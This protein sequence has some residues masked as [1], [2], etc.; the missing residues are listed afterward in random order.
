MHR[1]FS[2]SHPSVSDSWVWLGSVCRGSFESWW[3]FTAERRKMWFWVLH[4]LTRETSWH[5]WCCHENGDT[6]GWR[7]ESLPPC[8]YKLSLGYSCAAGLNIRPHLEDK[9]AEACKNEKRGERLARLTP[10]F[11]LT[12]V[13]AGGAVQW[14]FI[15]FYSNA[16]RPKDS[17]C[18]ERVRS[19][20]PLA[21]SG[22]FRGANGSSSGVCDGWRT[23]LQKLEDSSS[24]L[25]HRYSSLEL[26]TQQDLQPG[27]F[28]MSHCPLLPLVTHPH[29]SAHRGATCSRW[30]KS[31]GTSL[32]HSHTRGRRASLLGR[33]GTLHTH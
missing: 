21:S 29:S 3:R 20:I 13:W 5:S 9:T 17:F 14:L 10:C 23:P 4:L 33:A 26:H 15:W 16:S 12:T 18:W 2:A 7:T 25:I 30:G 28:W 22:S 31:S 11:L 6:L 8:W 32:G 1:I 27:P 24:F 19:F